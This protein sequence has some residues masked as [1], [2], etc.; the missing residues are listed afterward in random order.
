MAVNSR[1][2]KSS[3]T[4][5]ARRTFLGSVYGSLSGSSLT[6]SEYR[7][8]SKK[9]MVW[10][11]LPAQNA[12]RPFKIL[13]MASSTLPPLFTDASTLDCFGGVCVVQSGAEVR[14]IEIDITTLM[15]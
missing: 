9:E 2:L 3:G 8:I 7:K 6:D 12:K 15:Y 5:S 11:S 14:G 1:F 10:N 13:N 4:V